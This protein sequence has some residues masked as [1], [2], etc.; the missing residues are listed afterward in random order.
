MAVEPEVLPPQKEEKPGTSL[1]RVNLAAHIPNSPEIWRGEPQTDRARQLAFKLKSD[2]SAREA[3]PLLAEWFQLFMQAKKDYK[4]AV[5]KRKLYL[6]STANGDF[7][8]AFGEDDEDGP[9][10]GVS[11]IKEILSFHKDSVKEIRQIA[12]E[13]MKAAEARYENSLR[14]IKDA[15]KSGADII[16][17]AN[18]ILETSARTTGLH[19]VELSKVSMGLVAESFKTA[20]LGLEQLQKYADLVKSESPSESDLEMFARRAGLFAP[21]L[22]DKWNAS[23]ATKKLVMRILESELEDE[24]K[25]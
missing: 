9:S 11:I 15:L 13:S 7:T 22:M 3:D 24:K 5:K 20:Q 8:F 12:T 14:E 1:T 16:K 18:L 23:D 2:K 10:E 6:S 19:N 17:S 4:V 21:I 25:K